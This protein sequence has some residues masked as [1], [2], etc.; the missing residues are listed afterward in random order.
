MGLKATLEA[1]VK[2]AMLAKNEVG[3]TPATNLEE[4][5]RRTRSWLEENR[6]AW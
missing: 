6:W 4:G 3:W 5:L 1:D 2:T